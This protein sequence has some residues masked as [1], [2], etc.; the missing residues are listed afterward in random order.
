MELVF[1][2]TQNI[3]KA[4]SSFNIR[5]KNYRLICTWQNT[6]P[7]CEV[8][9]ILLM[10]WL[11]MQNSKFTLIQTIQK[12]LY[13]HSIIYKIKKLYTKSVTSFLKSWQQ[14]WCGTFQR[15]GRHSNATL[16]HC[17]PLFH[18]TTFSLCP[19]VVSSCPKNVII[20]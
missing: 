10:I 1:C 17:C 13:I 19:I 6:I 14:K 18:C 11:N 5:Q 16:V 4:G 12:Y 2:N 8:F 3:A 20:C 15:L 9:Q 7:T